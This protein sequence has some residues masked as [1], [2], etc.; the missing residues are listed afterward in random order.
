MVRAGEWKGRGGWRSG[1]TACMVQTLVRLQLLLDLHVWQ[2]AFVCVCRNG[3]ALYW[4][5]S[6]TMYLYACVFY[7]I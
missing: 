6:Y 3:Y 4:A 2:R 5:S 1:T 7:K